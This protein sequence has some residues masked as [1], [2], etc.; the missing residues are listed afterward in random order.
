MAA[1]DKE[2]WWMN[3]EGSFGEGQGQGQ[4]KGQ[5]QGSFGEGRQQDGAGYDLLGQESAPSVQG[6]QG[7]EPGVWIQ[8]PA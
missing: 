8:G 1:A 2:F 3:S 6:S 7:G 4:G 5:G